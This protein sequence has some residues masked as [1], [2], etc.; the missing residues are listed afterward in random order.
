MEYEKS[1][2]KIQNIFGEEIQISFKKI[3]LVLFDYDTFVILRKDKTSIFTKLGYKV[4][5]RVSPQKI[6]I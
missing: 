5:K 1:F 3:E 6:F 4:L 2:V